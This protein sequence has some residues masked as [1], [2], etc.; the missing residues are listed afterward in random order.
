MAGLEEGGGGNWDFYLE[1]KYWSS[2]AI[3]SQNNVRFGE[4]DSFLSILII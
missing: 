1:V 3:E 4:L 2:L